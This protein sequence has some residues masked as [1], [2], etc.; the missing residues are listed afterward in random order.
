[1]I[2]TLTPNPA[3]D[4]TYL[5]DEV[6]VHGEHRVREVRAAA[7]GKGLNVARVLAELGV[8]A[9]C[10]GPL[11][12]GVGQ[13][14][15][16]LLDPLPSIRQAWTPIA[17]TT[18]RTVTVVGPGGATAFNEPG[19]AVTPA[20]LRALRESLTT[21]VSSSDPRI[22]AVTLNGSL[23]PGLTGSDLAHLIRAAFDQDRPV[24]VDTSGPALL[25]A[26]RAGATVLKP[27]AAEAMDATGTDT[28][29][30]A[31]AALISAGARIVVCSLGS[32][33]LLALERDDQAHGPPRAWRAQL[34]EPL[35]GNPTGAGDALVAALA[36]RLL[37]AQASLP[38]VLARAVA[39]SASAV[40]R[41][42]A[43]EVDLEIAA[44]LETTVEIEEIRCP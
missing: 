41:P 24:L 15:C 6:R 30:E 23:P 1:M 43:G 31:A 22:E 36:S 13:E 33:G 27:N 9:I 11:G 35:S 8:D 29:L 21:L 5:V 42:V 16:E 28:P 25:T 39:V 34:P 10:A 4:L 26:A 14:L 3:L 37:A 19:P 18:R 2:L 17:G 32:E 20:E 38:D 12:G 40:T 7:G 44:Q